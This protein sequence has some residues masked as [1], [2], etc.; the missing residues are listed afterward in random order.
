[1]ERGRQGGLES[2]DPFDLDSRA[3]E[4]SPREREVVFRINQKIA[5]TASLEE[6]MEF[7]F[8]ATG[9]LCGRDRLCLLM[10]DEAGQSAVMQWTRCVRGECLR[11]RAG[12][13]VDLPDPVLDAALGS[14]RATVIDDLLRA[15]FELPAGNWIEELVKEGARSCMVCP[16]LVNDRMIGALVSA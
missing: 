6:A 2:R 16:L 11:L 1:M 3:A 4:F 9:E 7:L 5:A 13:V 10:L 12:Y 8:E 14:G 15:P